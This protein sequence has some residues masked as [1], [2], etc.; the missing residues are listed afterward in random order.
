MYRLFSFSPDDVGTIY[1]ITNLGFV[2]Q[3]MAIL[4]KAKLT[5]ANWSQRGLV[6]AVC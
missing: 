6:L 2:N 4:I 1:G 3:A 5:N